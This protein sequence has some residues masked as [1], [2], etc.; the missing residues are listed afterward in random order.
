MDRYKYSGEHKDKKNNNRV[1]NTTI[2]PK[3]DPT[4]HD[5][6]IISKEGDRIDI[7]ANR[8]YDDISKWWIIAAANNIGKGTMEIP[9]GRQIRIPMNVAE[10]VSALEENQKG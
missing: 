3:L 5:L 8:Y 1:I 6:Y 10:Y 2:Y 4:N 9:S 7:F